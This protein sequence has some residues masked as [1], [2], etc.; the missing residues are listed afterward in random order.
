MN[1]PNPNNAPVPEARRLAIWQL[2]IVIVCAALPVVPALA[3][4]GAWLVGVVVAGLLLVGF[5]IFKAAFAAAMTT[6]ERRIVFGLMTAVPLAL[7]VYLF[8]VCP[9]I[10]FG[11]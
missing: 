3:M 10:K 4:P 8:A 6:R 9:R 2:L 11:T 5:A 1:T 7:F